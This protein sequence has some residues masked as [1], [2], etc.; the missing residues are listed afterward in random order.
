MESV[1]HAVLGVS[2]GE[3][4]AGK[5]LGYKAAL[6]GAMLETIPDLDYIFFPLLTHEE[7][8]GFH[9][10]ATHSLLFSVVAPLIIIPI[11][12]KLFA[13]ARTLDFKTHYFL[14]FIAFFTHIV[15]D[16]FTTYGT[17]VFW[18]FSDYQASFDNISIF[19][20][21]YTLPLL[22]GLSLTWYCRRKNLS[23]DHKRFQHFNAIGLTLS[24]VY[25]ASTFVVKSHVNHVFAEQLDKQQITYSAIDSFPT[26]GNNILWRGI[27]SVADGYYEGLYSIFDGDHEVKWHRIARHEELLEKYK[28]TVIVQTL[29]WRTMGLYSVS[30]TENGI[31]MHD[32]KFGNLYYGL[33]ETDWVYSYTVEG[34][35][36]HYSF[37]T[38][39]ADYSH[40]ISP[41]Y[42]RHVF[43][44]RIRGD[45]VSF[46][47]NLP[48]IGLMLTHKK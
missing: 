15:L 6:Y 32:L 20:P 22:I 33:P 29:K 1:T 48:G 21:M 30:A 38:K 31:A 47:N 4:I 16:C 27:A 35:P 28:D 11:V 3:L 42:L 9:R 5:K 8:L 37:E 13:F 25:L 26:I 23:G 7:Q 24:V 40:G 12:N 10:S 41:V 44:P 46:Y 39:T 45:K 34:T 19:D 43:F 36:E 17:L 2:L 18:P 14:I